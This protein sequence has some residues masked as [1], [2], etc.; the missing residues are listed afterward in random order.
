MQKKIVLIGAGN[1][2]KGYIA[3]LFYSRGY[4]LVFL[5]HSMRQTLSMRREGKYPFYKVSDE[6]EMQ[7]RFI[8]GYEVYSTAEEREQCVQALCQTQYAS[9]HLYPKSY[10]DIA[11]L[12]A[13]VVKRKVEWAEQSALD[14]LLCVNSIRP[15]KVF[16]KLI[17]E[18]LETEEQRAYFEKNIGLIETLTNRGGYEPDERFL[19][20]HP[21]AVIVSGSEDLPADQEA[22]KGE[23]PADAP[24]KLLDRFEGRLINK[25]WSGNMRHASMALYSEFLGGTQM[26]RVAQDPYSCMCI[27]E[28]GE[29]ALFAVTR[30]FGFTLEELSEGSHDMR[31]EEYWKKLQKKQ[32]KDSVYRVAADPIR[33]LEKEERMV[34]PALACIRHGRLP[35]FISKSIA[36]MYRFRNEKD[37]Q[38]VELEEYIREH[39]LMAAMEKYSGLSDDVPEE[40]LLKQLVAAQDRDFQLQKAVR[41]AFPKRNDTSIVAN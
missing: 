11:E 8:S 20:E 7:E 19:Q 29:E 9:V 41:S 15:A 5:A 26:W 25:L 38:A 18:Q 13:R 27:D 39:G 32:D 1:I 28:A 10:P 31:Y 14:V 30:E 3:D 23:I 34:G 6:G 35:Y 33:K 21:N 24:L 4:K 40:K 36:L 16:R 22:F 17:L 2:G 12:L 37:E